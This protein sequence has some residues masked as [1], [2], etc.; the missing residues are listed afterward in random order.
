MKINCSN[1]NTQITLNLVAETA[2]H[3]T[4]GYGKGSKR[5]P[6]KTRSNSLWIDSNGLVVWDAPCCNLNGVEVYEDS[7]EPWMY[8]AIN[9]IIEGL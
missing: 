1:C 7:L 8:P 4:A 5:V 2:E 9:K 3:T 6:A